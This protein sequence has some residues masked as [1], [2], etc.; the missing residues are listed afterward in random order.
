MAYLYGDSTPFPLDENFL[1]TL[2]DVTEAAVALLKV[3]GAIAAAKE[4]AEEAR[5]ESTRE[6][7]RIEGLAAS[8][9]RAFEGALGD[10]EVPQAAR[11]ASRALQ[12]AR[13][14][15]ENARGECTSRR[16]DALRMA[17]RDMDERRAQVPKIVESLLS[18]RQLPG[19]IWRLR[20]RAGAGEQVAMAQVKGTAPGGL[21]A[22]LDLDVPA[23]HL[24]AHGVKVAGLARDVVVRLPSDGGM[25]RSAGRVAERLD[26]WFVTE[27]EVSP[28]RTCLVLRKSLKGPSEGLEIVIRSVDGPCPAVRRMMSGGGAEGPVVVVDGADATSLDRLWR[29]IAETMRDLEKRRGRLASAVAMGKPLAAIERPGALAA[30]FVDAVAPLAREIRR[31]SAAPTELSLKRELG[32]GRREELFVPARELTVK[33]DGLSAEQRSMFEVFGLDLPALPSVI[34]Q[35][36]VSVERPLEALRDVPVRPLGKAA[37]PA[38]MPVAMIDDVVDA[39]VAEED[40]E[41]DPTE[42]EKRPRGRVRETAVLPPM[43][44]P[45]PMAVPV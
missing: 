15:L 18:R 38:V 13:G 20:W 24:W 30:L 32:N 44:M 35:D 7:V 9:G 26:R 12:A 2:R 14:V 17:E 39:L 3:D 31:R 43:P 11:V 37:M 23:S 19:T 10:Q 28:E 1:D 40:D 33:M 25:F 22:V 6:Q 5:R 8:L 34:S 29:R 41:E 21:E 36:S 42:T 45:M 16:D 27:V 4:R